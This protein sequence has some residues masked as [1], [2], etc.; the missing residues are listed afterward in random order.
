MA[1]GRSM[2]RLRGDTPRGASGERRANGGPPGRRLLGQLGGLVVRF[3]GG[4]A[5]LGTLGTEAHA[6][7]EVAFLIDTTG[8]MSGEIREATERVRQIAAT[9]QAA[10]PG[11]RI[12]VGVVAFRDRG[13]AYL[14]QVSPLSPE[15]ETTWGFLARLRAE[16]GGDGPEDLLSGLDATLHSLQWSTGTDVER[17][18]FLIGDAPPHLDYS[19]GPRLAPLL[20]EANARRI[21]IH[22]VGCRS[23][24]SEGV[25]F[26]REVAYGTEG[27][28][29]H[30]GR[31]GADGLGLSEAVLSA[32]VPEVDNTPLTNVRV[33]PGRPSPLGEG[34]PLVTLG[35]HLGDWG[36]ALRRSPEQD[37]KTTCTLTLVVP[38]GVGVRG[39]PQVG[40]GADRLDVVV[41]LTDS[42]E[43]AQLQQFDLSPCVPQT[44]PVHLRLEN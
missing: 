17:Q 42:K 19:D 40:L 39:R 27:T 4:L 10:R 41:D 37:A 9:L 22:T 8:S 5:A 21:I 32:L 38:A 36:P 2:R 29:Q 34:T 30:I 3:L 1:V 24:P 28:Y 26:F 18:V 31:V 16:G 13:D 25:N 23:L 43:P 35:A 11:E 14:T 44:L 15:I 6:A 33:A 12:S 7:M 20:E